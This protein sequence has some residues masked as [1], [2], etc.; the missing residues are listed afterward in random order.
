M[1]FEDVLRM[2]TWVVDVP[3]ARALVKRVHIIPL[4]IR[5]RAK[6]ICERQPRQ[7]CTYL[8]KSG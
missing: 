2:E 4:K 6:N 3:R 5:L 8:E 1:K 7:P